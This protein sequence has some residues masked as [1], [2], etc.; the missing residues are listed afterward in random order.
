MQL[1]FISVVF[2]ILIGITSCQFYS[3]CNPGYYYNTYGF[4]NRCERCPVGYY[5]PGGKEGRYA[6]FACKP[7]F[8]SDIGATKCSGCPFTL[9]CSNPVKPIPFAITPE[10]TQKVSTNL[11]QTTAE[12]TTDFIFGAI[13]GLFIEDKVEKLKNLAS[14]PEEMRVAQEKWANVDWENGESLKDAIT[15]TGKTFVDIWKAVGDFTKIPEKGEKVMLVFVAEVA[16]EAVLVYEASKYTYR[17]FENFVD[18]TENVK[19]LYNNLKEN[20][21]EEAGKAFGRLINDGIELKKKNDQGNSR[22]FRYIIE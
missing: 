12:K 18:V 16:P 22:G 10:N 6:P 21:M 11:K 20:K 3:D 1:Q 8:Y 5:C 19:S 15:C 2:S 14:I 17:L 4:F 13:E 9:D 7:G